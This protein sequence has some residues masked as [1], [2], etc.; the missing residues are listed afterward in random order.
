MPMATLYAEL[1][2]AGIKPWEVRLLTSWQIAHVIRHERDRQGQIVRPKRPANRVLPFWAFREMMAARG[3]SDVAAA[4]RWRS[5]Q[6][7]EA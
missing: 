7:R 3:L 5:M 4:E 2:D 1:L 6:S